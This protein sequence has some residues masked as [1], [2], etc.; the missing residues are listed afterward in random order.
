MIKSAVLALAAVTVP[1]T[2]SLGSGSAAVAP[3]PRDVML[4]GRIAGWF[5]EDDGT[6]LVSCAAKKGDVLWFRTPANQ[7]ST[8]QFELLTLHAVL[9]L[10]RLPVDAAT[11]VYFRGEATTSNNGSTPDKALQ[12]VAIGH[13]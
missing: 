7:S 13:K 2:S 6:V 10:Q 11:K 12:L 3:V 4:E 8:T 9:D 1:L 5:V